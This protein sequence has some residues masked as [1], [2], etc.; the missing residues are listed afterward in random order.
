M[1][2]LIEELVHHQLQEGFNQ[3]VGLGDF[4]EI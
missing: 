4:V 2:M 3:I 1:H